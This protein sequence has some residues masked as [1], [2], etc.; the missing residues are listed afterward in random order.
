VWLRD[1]GE[2]PPACAEA[3]SLQAAC[4]RL[5][6]PSISPESQPSAPG[7]WPSSGWGTASLPLHP[8]LAGWASSPLSFSLNWFSP[9]P[10]PFL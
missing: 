1:H 7:P 2:P 10:V 8:F 4:L 6:P 9:P 5:P 3:P